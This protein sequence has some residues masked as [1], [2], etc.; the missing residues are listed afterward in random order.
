[1]FQNA[2]NI[3]ISCTVVYRFYRLLQQ[4]D[5]TAIEYFSH[6]VDKY[7]TRRALLWKLNFYYN[8]RAYK[9]PCKGGIVAEPW[10]CWIYC[11]PVRKYKTNKK[12]GQGIKFEGP[13][14][15]FYWDSASYSLTIFPNIATNWSQSVQTQQ[16]MEGFL[17]SNFNIGLLFLITWC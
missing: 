17:Y 2:Q 10:G 15:H 7:L 12:W 4:E 13:G 5:M 6:G 11:I 9:T 14:S 1:M 8:S 16:S 3:V